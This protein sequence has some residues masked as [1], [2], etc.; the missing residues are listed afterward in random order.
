MKEEIRNGQKQRRKKKC[1]E[2]KKASGIFPL[3]R[4]YKRKLLKVPL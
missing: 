1:I 2:R 3:L 4:S